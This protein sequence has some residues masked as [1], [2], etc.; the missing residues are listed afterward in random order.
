M[1]E[2]RLTL[3]IFAQAGESSLG[4]IGLFLYDAATL[5]ELLRL[6][7]D[8]AYAEYR[9]EKY[10][11]YRGRRPLRPADQLR[12]ERIAVHGQIEI[13]ATV[14]KTRLAAVT[15]SAF[16]AECLSTDQGEITARL[17]ERGAARHIAT[18]LRRLRR[19]P[20]RIARIAVRGGQKT[21]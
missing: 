5:Y 9:F 18:V 11:L 4:E 13:H 8:P 10:P 15:L 20:I 14:A 7:L 19:S 1:A 3:V 16:K 12:V 6:G 2:D 21:S 17:E